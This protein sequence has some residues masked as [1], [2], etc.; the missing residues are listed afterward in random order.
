MWYVHTVEY[1]SA[2]KT[3]GNPAMCENI[4]D[5]EDSMIRWECLHHPPKRGAEVLSGVTETMQPQR[6]FMCRSSRDV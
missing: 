3:E 4:D 2:L 1:C 6:W 5:L